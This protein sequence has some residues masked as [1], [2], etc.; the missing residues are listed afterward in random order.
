MVLPKQQVPMLSVASTGY[1][2]HL[3]A[4]YN[5]TAA[6]ADW[7]NIAA[8]HGVNLTAPSTDGRA[9]VIQGR[10][11]PRRFNVKFVSNTTK[12]R[13]CELALLDYCCFNFPLP[14]PCSDLHCRLN[15]GATDSRLQIQP[16]AHPR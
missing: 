10:S 4:L 2:V 6:K 7:Q 5:T 3:D 9:G 14:P 8:S 1:P 12:Q 11:F 16:W 13:I 15:K